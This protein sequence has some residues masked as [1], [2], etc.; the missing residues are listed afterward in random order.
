MCLASIY[1][2]RH[3]YQEAIDVYKKI[4]LDKKHYAALNIYIALCYYKLDY[5]D[6]SQEVLALYLQKNLS[7]II[8]GNLKACNNY[9]LFN[10]VAAEVSLHLFYINIYIYIFNIVACLSKCFRASFVI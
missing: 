2:Y 6:V 4:L 7:S 9:R 5:Y 3:Q 8:A 1:F 10:G